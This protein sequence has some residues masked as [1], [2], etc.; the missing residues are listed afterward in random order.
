MNLS[1]WQAL[2]AIIMSIITPTLAGVGSYYKSQASTQVEMEKLRTER[3]EQYV[4][5]DAV[6]KLTDKVD[7]IAKD[8]AAI[9]G[10]IEGQRSRR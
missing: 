7:A 8:T 6:D 9:R 10:Y 5:K 1:K 2:V 4:R 3:A